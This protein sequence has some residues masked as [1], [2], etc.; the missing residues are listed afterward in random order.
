MTQ[1]FQL[2][3]KAHMFLMTIFDG[4]NCCDGAQCGL[5]SNYGQLIW[6]PNVRLCLSDLHS[7]RH[8]SWHEDDCHWSQNPRLPLYR[9]WHSVFGWRRLFVYQKTQPYCTCS[10]EHICYLAHTNISPAWTFRESFST[11][12]RRPR[13]WRNCSYMTLGK[14]SAALVSTSQHVIQQ[15]SEK[16]SIHSG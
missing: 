13:G 10:C 7:Y 8:G 9:G 16:L 4:R 11:W 14:M 12:R 2:M 3:I 5:F 15:Y 1:K 6:A